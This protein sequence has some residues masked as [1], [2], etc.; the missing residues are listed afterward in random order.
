VSNKSFAEIR[1]ELAAK[2][3]RPLNQDQ[4]PPSPVEQKFDDDLIPDVGPDK[5]EE[6]LEIDS[7]IDSIGIVDAYRKFI[8]KKIDEST[9]NRT[10]NIMVTCPLHD[11][12]KPSC[13]MNAEKKV[14]H[15]GH[16]FVVVTSTT[17]LLSTSACRTTKMALTSTT[18]QKDR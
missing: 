3:G 16:D 6:D 15:C 8:G 17:L 13:W 5:S 11:E 10:E 9:V 2:R 12:D 14:W 18:P 4:R 7:I 1:E